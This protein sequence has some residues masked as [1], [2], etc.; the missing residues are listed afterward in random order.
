M[1]G[2]SKQLESEMNLMKESELAKNQKGNDI[3]SLKRSI[4]EV[5]ES[6]Q[7]FQV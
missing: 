7:K 3:K 1:N 6:I 4:Q 2:L 5:E